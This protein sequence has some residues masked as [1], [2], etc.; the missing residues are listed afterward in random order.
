MPHSGKNVLED[1]YNQYD[2]GEMFFR[3]HAS[4]NHPPDPDREC[5]AQGKIFRILQPLNKIFDSYLQIPGSPGPLQTDVD[6]GIPCHDLSC[7]DK[8]PAFNVLSLPCPAVL[9]PHNDGK[10]GFPFAFNM[11]I[12]CVIVDAEKS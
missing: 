3:D 7:L 6:Q 11:P 2:H 9:I 4:Q 5:T 12:L 8:H 1:R 10:N